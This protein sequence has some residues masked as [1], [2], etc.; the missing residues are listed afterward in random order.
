MRKRISLV[1][2]GF[3]L[4]LSSTY[5][6]TAFFGLVKAGTPQ[7]VQSALNLGA[8]VNARGSNARTSLM[9]AA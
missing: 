5:A 3:L 1:A 8:D 9:F 2:L 7:D 6:Q 4:A